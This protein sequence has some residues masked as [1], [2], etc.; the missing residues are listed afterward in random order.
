MTARTARAPLFFAPVGAGNSPLPP[1]GRGTAVA[2]CERL[3]IAAGNAT[4]KTRTGPLAIYAAC[5][6]RYPRNSAR[7]RPCNIGNSGAG[8]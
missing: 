8:A 2:R 1:E 5:G 6:G 4:G 3:R 7:V